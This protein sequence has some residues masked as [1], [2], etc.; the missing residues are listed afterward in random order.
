[1]KKIAVLGISGSVGD[2][3]LKVIRKF[4]SNFK[5]VAFS[6][7]K[8]W[9][10]AEELIAEFKPELVCISSPDS[11]SRTLGKNI[12]KTKIVYGEEGLNEIASLN[13]MDVLVTA[14]VGAA[15]IL[16]TIEAIRNNKDIA[17]ANKETLV[18]YGPIIN[19]LLKFSN[20]KLIPVDSEHNALFQLLESKPKSSIRSITL[21]ASGGSFRNLPL[22]QLSSVTVAQALNHPTWSMGPKIT[23]DSAGLVN[24]GLE[25][26]EAHYLFHFP[27]DQI[28]VVIHPESIV[29]GLIETIDGAVTCYA[30]HPDMIYPVAHSLFY[31][32]IVPELLIE[33]KPFSWKTLN[34]QSPDLNRF[35]ALGLAYSAGKAGGTRPAIFNGSNEIA[36]DLFLKEKISFIQIPEI[37][38]EA[39][40][41]IPTIQSNE[42]GDFREADQNARNFVLKKYNNGVAIC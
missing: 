27:Y 29:H 32:E 10:K 11:E 1:M 8:N 12:H 2:S 5:L 33:R 31:P 41:H 28:E 7:H 35:P 37:I 42:L 9:K 19:Y 25:V 14:V 6:V 39:M 23:I 30:S 22:E 34:F 18:T 21:T 16:P 40:D 4:P 13:S 15:G 38:H 24:K 20:S 3:T 17:I 36:V 26:I